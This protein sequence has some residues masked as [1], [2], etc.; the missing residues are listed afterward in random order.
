MQEV[1][2]FGEHLL[3]GKWGHFLVVLAF[4]S[5][6]VSSVSYALA[7]HRRGQTEAI[8]WRQIGRISFL[9]ECL[10]VFT[11]IGIIFYIMIN[12][13]YEYEYVQAHVAEELPFKYIFTAFW[14]GQQGSFL[15]W[16]FWHAILGLAMLKW[17]KEWESPTM[18]VLG[19]VQAFLLSMILGIY[20]LPDFR[21]GVTAFALL[22]ETEGMVDLPLFSN[23]NYVELIRGKGLNPLLQNYWMLIHPPTLFLGFASVTVPFAFAVS[24]FWTRQYREWLK[25]VLPWALFSTGILGTG[26]LMGG[27]WAYEALSFG[28]YWAWDPVENASFV[29]WLI[30]IAGLH[31]N[32]VANST[33]RSIKATYVFYGL[34][35][36]LILYSTFLTRSGILGDSSVHAFTE[37][38]LEWQL[39]FF[40][41]FFAALLLLL[42][43]R[44]QPKIVEPSKEEAF[45][46]REFWMFI[47]S[48]VL[49]FGA[50]LITFTTSL[51]VYNTLLDVY[52]SLVG[53]D[54]T[55]LHMASPED[56]ISHYN[57][58]QLWIAF[59]VGLL[60]GIAQFLIYNDQRWA[61]RKTRVMRSIGI[62]AL[63]AAALTFLQQFWI[64]ANSLSYL[65]LLFSANFAIATNLYYLISVLKLK[66]RAAA[67]VLA[68]IGFGLMIIGIM[69]SGL[70]K[71]Y[72]SSNS[73][74][75]QG[76]F[77]PGDER[78]AKNVFLIKGRP[79][80]MGDYRATYLADTMIEFDRHYQVLI[81]KLAEDKKTVIEDFEVSPYLTYNTQKTEVVNPNP[82]T[83]RYLH[84]DIF[85]HITSVP[86]HR[87]SIEAAREIDDSLNYRTFLLGLNDTIRVEDTYLMLRSVSLNPTHP[88]YHAEPDDLTYG[89]EVMAWKDQVPPET[90]APV[91]AIKQHKY[92]YSY[93]DQ[94]NDLGVRLRLTEEGL[95]RV[96][97]DD[98]KLDYQ[99]F[100][101]KQGDTF[102][103][104]DYQFYIRGFD[105][106][107]VHPSYKPE[108]GDIAVALIID[109][110]APDGRQG[111]S[112]PVFLIRDNKTYLVKDYLPDLGLAIKF[113]SIDPA[114]ESLDLLIA[115][116]NVKNLSI[117]VQVATDAPRDDY[118]V[119]EAIEFPGINLFWLGTILMM[120][121]AFLGMFRRMKVI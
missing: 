70:N 86:P 33:G 65:F 106:D 43:V 44:H 20:I 107:P 74:A 105:K 118:I 4:V 68:H 26:I 115:E 24:G 77:G 5:A 59:F 113:A 66:M 37:M 116:N 103:Y 82:S 92:I 99:A 88:E 36:L 60:T 51:P 83:K 81:E 97:L 91:L 104:Q 17:T 80:L 90:I 28:G 85:S 40:M 89:V 71:R 25:P 119:L 7:T 57:R 31:T 96:Y 9:L 75:M 79:L 41:V 32:L 52:G 111:L 39:I 73:F 109:V 23:A 101:Q 62:G 112:K 35:F 13:Y 100:R 120:G 64:E 12:Q 63:F 72:I 18:S 47:G 61:T 1:A 30:L 55:D 21:L 76:I 58:F 42:Y 3:P 84:K 19:A 50:G 53:S 16:I 34:S 49:L 29:P 22:R 2:Y 14:E 56:P 10:S 108:E 95:D 102:E 45:S 87:M 48:L 69:A 93:Y 117:P 94:A 38:G 54:L 11:A 114:T 67:S 6:L 15:L 121:G 78:A 98:S 46:S 8:Q 110:L 27:A